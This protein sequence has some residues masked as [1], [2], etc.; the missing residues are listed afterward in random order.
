MHTSPARTPARSLL[1]A[2]SALTA[3]GL[4]TAGAAALPAMAQAATP[5]GSGAASPAAVGVQQALAQATSSG[6]AVQASAATTNSSTLTANPNGTLTLSQSLAPVRKKV[7]GSWHNLDATLVKNADGSISPSVSTSALSLSGGGSGPLASMDDAGR[8]LAVSLPMAL[9]TPSL[10]GSTAT[11]TNVL[12][13]VDLSVVVDA[14][15][16]FEDTLIVKTAAA[17]ANPAL[18]TL[19]LATKTKALKLSA[20]SAGNV[21]AKDASGHPVYTSQAAQMWDSATQAVSTPSKTAPLTSSKVEAAAPSSAPVAS[22]PP[23]APVTDP[24]TGKL[25]DPAT[26]QPIASSATGPGLG[27]HTAPIATSVSAQTISLTPTASL[28]TGP[29][30]VY[31]V[32][33]DPTFI[34][35]SAA[36]PLDSWTNINSNFHGTSYWKTSGQ[37]QVGDQNWQS[38]TFVSR[39]F[40]QLSIPSQIYDSTILSSSLNFTEDWSPSCN[41]T[42]V[43]LWQSSYISSGTTWDNPPTLSNQV[44]ATQTVAHGYNSSCPTAGVGFDMSSAMANAARYHWS[45]LTLGLKAADES[46]QYG[47]KQFANTVTY[48]TTY[49]HAPNTPDT[50]STSPTTSCTGSTVGDGDVTLYARESD[51]DGGTVGVAFSA[52][53]HATGA[54][55][56]SSDSTVLTAPSGSTLALKIPKAT[57][58]AAANSKALQVDWQ[59]MGNDFH[60]T[61]GWSNLCSFTFDP[62]RPGAP[63]ITLPSNSANCPVTAPVAGSSNPPTVGAIAEKCAFTISPAPGGVTPSSYVYQLNG[64]AP[65]ALAASSGSVTITPGRITNTLTV[66][67]LSAGANY[68]DTA[69]TVFTSAAPATPAA[70]SDLT[71]SG[72]AD[73]LTVGGQHQLPAGLWLNSGQAGPGHPGNGHINSSATDIGLHGSGINTTGGTGTGSPADYAGAI[74]F[75]GRFTNDNLQDVLVYYPAGP[76]A[77][78]GEII[79]GNG[80]GSAL[81]STSATII[82]SGALFDSNNDSPVQLA[83]AGNTTGDNNPYPDLIGISGDAT[84]G[85]SL[86]LYPG[87]SPIGTYGTQGGIGNTIPVINTST[88]APLPTPAGGADWNSWTIATTQLPTTSPTP[89][90]AMYLWNKSTGDLYL[91]TGLAY[92]ATTGALGYTQTKVAAGWNTN[93]ALTLQAADINGDGTPDLWATDASGKVTANLM[94]AGDSAFQGTAPTDTLAPLAH[95]WDLDD[96]TSG[97]VGAN[98]ATDQAGSTP[99]PLSAVGTGAPS[100][101][102]GDVFSPDISMNTGVA[103]TSQALTT[104]APALN[105]SGDFSLSIWARPNILGGVTVSQSGAHSSGLIVFPDANTK[106]WF[107]CLAPTDTTGWVYDCV[108]GSSVTTGVWTHLTVTYSAANKLMALYV[109][110]VDA[111][112]GPHTPVASTLFRGNLVVGDYLYNNAPYSYFNGAV[113]Q[114]QTWSQALTPNQVAG[115]SGTPGAVLFPSDSTTYP[116]GSSWSSNANTMS[117][118]QG[119]LTVTVA[120]SPLYQ[121]GTASN[122]GAVMTMQ[123]DGNLVAYPTATDAANQTNALWA[124]GTNGDT[125]A[126]LLLQPDGNLVLYTANGAPAWV[127][128]TSFLGADQWQLTSATAGADTAGT[129]PAAPSSSVTW[130]ANHD[131]TANGAAVFN[132]TDSV[133]RATAPAVNSSTS[134]TVSCWLKI[135]A[136]SGSQIALGQGTVNH[137]AFY[138][139]YSNAMGGWIFQTTTTDDA[140]SAFPTAMSPATAGTWTHLTGVYDVG[141]HTMTLYV[142]GVAKATATNTTPQY[143][144]GGPLDI[145]ANSLAGSTALYDQVNG[146]VSDVRTYPTALSAAQVTTLYSNSSLLSADQ[147]QLTSATAGADTAGTNPAAP[148]SSVTWAANHDGTANGAAVFNGTDSVVRATAPAVNSSTSYTVSCWLKINALS[149]SQIALGQGTVNH[150]AFYLGYSNAMGGWIFQTTTTDDA[151]S[152]FPT[153]MSPATAG[154]WTHL[155]GVYDVGSH[156][157]TLYVNGVAK[158]TATNTTPQYN[159]GGPLDI[160]ANSLAGSTALY[161][162]VNGS[163]SDV[164]TY[165]TALSAAQVTTLYSNS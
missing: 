4:L 69:S 33:I 76:H 31:P 58:E 139:G 153:A 57:L 129:N 104:S 84:S 9:P 17:A 138:L 160:G 48:D 89:G 7:G 118:N 86:N 120:G 79:P 1:R 85:Y 110:G 47:W 136:L 155:T 67:S 106:Q 137:Q 152:A 45:T 101:G 59:A 142:N 74:A 96:Q 22:A 73:L 50:L 114:L 43:Q 147:W 145:G 54:T 90:T 51:Q 123:S 10:S 24:T 141:S 163:V 18:K 81:N 125:G 32:Y 34:A 107:F 37:L 16:G 102:T 72:I 146:S 41:A 108:H 55:I 93:A 122:P 121:V 162:Q 164:R 65:H 49:D 99:L 126:S 156:T 88:G 12:P 161:D 116:S 157:M 158:A 82:Q 53:N 80:D 159:T 36:T 66:T 91:W 60:F 124:T 143:N 94:A 117:F 26:G 2:L 109:N 21:S 148:S 92:N 14:Q 19:Q 35:P 38:P 6:K 97:A 23:S 100:W 63:V 46:D 165:P 154:T 56:A 150:Q 42:G 40:V 8:S 119:Q 29:G 30:T 95:A 134:Y 28:L 149:G 128:N 70:D 98:T 112:S 62:T 144:T 151:S 135:N 11:Y 61:S 27:A 87:S 133:V 3:L 131:G 127:S 5:V 140:S 103:T 39:S 83:N 71:G 78:V 132:G 15:G 115:A 64:G 105:L 25:V 75:S 111:A 20:D 68:G 13:S 77:G 44:G 52:V 130:A 113:S